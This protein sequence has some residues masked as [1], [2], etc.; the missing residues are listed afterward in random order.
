MI[1]QL[2][3][4]WIYYWPS[5]YVSKYV[6][7]FLKSFNVCAVFSPQRWHV[8]IYYWSTS[9]EQ[10][11]HQRAAGRAERTSSKAWYWLIHHIL[12]NQLDWGVYE[13]ENIAH[14]LNSYNNCY[15]SYCRKWQC[16]CVNIR[17][18][19]NLRGNESSSRELF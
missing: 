7:K 16:C 14:S 1:I 8:L 3:L 10:D 18:K 6:S 17:V 4:W 11:E 15:S 12:F 5:K 2:I 9:D 13:Q 19:L